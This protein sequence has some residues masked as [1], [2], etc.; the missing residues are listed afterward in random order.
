M[1]DTTRIEWCD[2]TFNPWIGCTRISPACDACYAAVST[3]ART[4]RIEWGA[5][6]LRHRTSETAW[7]E[8]LRWE[9]QHEKFF[10]QHRRRRRV[11]CA[12][13]ADVFDNEVDPQ[14]RADLMELILA[15]KHL[16]WLLLTKRIGNVQGMIAEAGDLIDYGE[17]WQSL[18]GQGDWPE[19]VM[20]GSTIADQGELRRDLWKLFAVPARRKF[21]SYEPALGLLDAIEVMQY[22]DVDL[23]IAGGESGRDARPAPIEWFRS[24]R[25][26]CR[27]LNTAFFMKQL[28]GVRDKRGNIEDLPEDLRIR[29]FPEVSR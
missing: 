11:F 26:Q 25:D 19:H 10:A 24:I 17:G 29:E 16:D 22:W 8:P 7:K 15:T 27:H 23:L 9:R 14:W 2:S 13:L 20:L 18:W 1:A 5:S 12:S 6:K 21:I 3:P 4:L 28:G